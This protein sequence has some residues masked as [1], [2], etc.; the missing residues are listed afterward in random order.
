VSGN[1]GGAIW[2]IDVATG[3]RVQAAARGRMAIWLDDHTLLV[4]V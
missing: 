2:V 1:P 4:G 3:E